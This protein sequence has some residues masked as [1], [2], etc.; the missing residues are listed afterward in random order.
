MMLG[1]AFVKG[2]VALLSYIQ[3][4][5]TEAGTLQLCTAE[6]DTSVWSVRNEG[7]ND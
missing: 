7:R 2:N 5:Y 6:R 3:W 4:F 1:D